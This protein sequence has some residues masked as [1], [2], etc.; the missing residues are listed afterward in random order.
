MSKENL[1]F[2]VDSL[3]ITSRAIKLQEE[4]AELSVETAKLLNKKEFDVNHFVEEYFDVRD[5]VEELILY[6][7]ITEEEMNRFREIKQNRTIKYIKE[8]NLTEIKYLV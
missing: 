3:G 6:Y 8:N 2:I 7:N 1:K 5:L 4:L